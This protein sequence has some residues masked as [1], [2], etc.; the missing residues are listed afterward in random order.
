MLTISAILFV[1]TALLTHLQHVDRWDISPWGLFCS[2]T[3]LSS[4][5][6]ILHFERLYF[7]LLGA[8]IEKH[9]YSSFSRKP[10][11]TDLNF[12]QWKLYV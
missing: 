6:F 8:W 5:A 7:F 1:L 3:S 2:R 4:D 12:R 10:N 9:K 11:S